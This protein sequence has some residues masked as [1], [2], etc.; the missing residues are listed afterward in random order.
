VKRVTATQ[1]ARN[2]ADLLDAV[3][4]RRESFEV[5]RKGRPVARL[6]PSS[7]PNGAATKRALERFRPDPA[8][9]DEIRGVRELLVDS[10]P[11]HD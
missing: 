10:D 5:V 2:L 11:W 6:T 1:F 9:A 3:E 4:H 8:W 7:A